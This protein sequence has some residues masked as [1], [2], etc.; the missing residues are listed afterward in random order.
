MNLKRPFKLTPIETEADLSKL[1]FPLIAL[2]KYDGIRCMLHKGRLLSCTLKDIPNRYISH[3]L[4]P[5]AEYVGDGII[6]GELIRADTKD[7][8]KVQ[9]VVMSS[10][11]KDSEQLRYVMFDRIIQGTKEEHA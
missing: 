10:Q 2:P 6:D 1:K 5:L 4:K 8:N 11:H 9:S 7:Y 3:L